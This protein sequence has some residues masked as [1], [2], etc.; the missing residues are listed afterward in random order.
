MVPFQPR[1][2]SAEEVRLRCIEARARFYSYPSMLK[3]SLDFEVNASDFFMWR[4]FF[5]INTMMRR[6]VT[7]RKELPLGDAAHEIELVKAS[8]TEPFDDKPAQAP[9]NIG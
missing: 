1:G 5:V 7:Q 8:H 2:M 4:N 9:L 6:E 3:R